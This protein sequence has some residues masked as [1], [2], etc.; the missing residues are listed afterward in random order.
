MSRFAN[1]IVEHVKERPQ[2][3]GDL[4]PKLK[5]DGFWFVEA[6]IYGALRDLADRGVLLREAIPGSATR[7]R[8]GLPAYRYS[9]AK[10]M[11][12]TPDA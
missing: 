9:L 10:P 12:W 5:R 8:G 2:R 11:L 1:R 3:A 6:R 4:V 7:E